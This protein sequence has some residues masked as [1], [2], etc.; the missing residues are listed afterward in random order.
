VS[1]W[2]IGSRRTNES[3]GINKKE[4]WSVWRKEVLKTSAPE[5]MM[6]SEAL[7]RKHTSSEAHFIISWWKWSFKRV[8]KGFNHAISLQ[9]TS[10]IKQQLIPKDL[11]TLEAYSLKRVEKGQL[12]ELYNHY[13]F[14]SLQQDKNNS[15]ACTSVPLDLEWI[16]NW[17]FIGQ[18][19]NQATIHWWFDQVSNDSF[20]CVG[21]QQRLFHTSI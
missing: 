18:Q 16:W 1:F 17:S 19:P 21:N 8:F 11:K 20:W 2:S 13:F 3:N 15:Y 9:K 4:T 5:V 7:H 6:S 14:L 12:Y 10:R